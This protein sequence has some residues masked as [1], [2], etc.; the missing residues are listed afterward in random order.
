MANFGQALMGTNASIQRVPTVGGT[1]R[2]TMRELLEQG[3]AIQQNP[4]EGFQPIAQQARTDFYGGSIPQLLER[5]TGGMGGGGAL[6]SPTMSALLGQSSQGFE[7]GLNAQREQFGQQNR[8]FGLRKI[9]MGLQPTFQNFQVPGQAGFAE[10]GMESLK[11]IL[12]MLLRAYLA[13]QTGG[14]TLAAE[15]G[16]DLLKNLFSGG[17]SESM[18][19]GLGSG[20]NAFSPYLNSRQSLLQG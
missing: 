11:T 16:F 17:G 4:Y 10:T 18:S 13:Y 6:S 5:L 3:K 2:R 12:P 1:E 7:Q 15:G 9:G 8:D 19:Q 20:A 14:G